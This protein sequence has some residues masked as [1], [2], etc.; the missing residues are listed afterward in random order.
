MSYIHNNYQTIRVF[1]HELNS[2]S[3]KP[4]SGSS[5]L[6]GPK[7][8]TLLRTSRKKIARYIFITITGILFSYWIWR[9]FVQTFFIREINSECDRENTKWP[10]NKWKKYPRKQSMTVH[11]FST[12]VIF[13]KIF[14][15]NRKIGFTLLKQKNTYP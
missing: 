5:V 7:G 2:D 9:K 6:W 14:T 10:W 1:V 4:C 3:K 13:R 8:P 12:I 15:G 11:I